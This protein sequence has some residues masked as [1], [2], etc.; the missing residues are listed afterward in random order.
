MQTYLHY[1]LQLLREACVRHR[2]G[3]E[4]GVCQ[5]QVHLVRTSLFHLKQAEQI[6]LGPSADNNNKLTP[7]FVISITC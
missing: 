3:Q 4:E 6:L 5:P 7:E 2:E 1:S